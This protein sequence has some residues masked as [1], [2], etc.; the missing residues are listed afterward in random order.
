[1]SAMIFSQKYVSRTVTCFN[2]LFLLRLW[3]RWQCKDQYWN[4]KR[5][6][7]IWI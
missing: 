2:V 3:R 7:R 5:H 1:M 4:T 6:V